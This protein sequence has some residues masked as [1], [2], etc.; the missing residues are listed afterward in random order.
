MY[1]NITNVTYKSYI[2]QSVHSD[3]IRQGYIFYKKNTEKNQRSEIITRA[4]IVSNYKLKNI[5]YHA[6]SV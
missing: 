4:G 3:E 6:L 1:T 5:H 2:I